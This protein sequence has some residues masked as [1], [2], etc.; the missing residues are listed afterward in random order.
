MARAEQCAADHAPVKA[1]DAVLTRRAGDRRGVHTVTVPL[2]RHLA[3]SEEH[4]VAME[5][6]RD[7]GIVVAQQPH[8]R[9]APQ[10]G[11]HVSFELIDRGVVHTG[12][13]IADEPHRRDV[14]RTT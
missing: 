14:L 2:Q 10:P 7:L 4:Q 1:H 12:A 8:R 9:V 5:G 13:Q 3:N 11:Y 6:R